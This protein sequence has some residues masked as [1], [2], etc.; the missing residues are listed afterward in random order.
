MEGIDMHTETVDDLRSQAFAAIS[1]WIRRDQE[2]FDCVVG[3][4][5]EA[6]V[7]LPVVIGELV[8]ALERSVGP[9]EVR[10]QVDQ[11]LDQFLEVRRQRLA[12]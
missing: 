12:G 10:R 1:A 8:S 3:T 2:A 5:E 7:L 4:D 9:A 6:A 11:F